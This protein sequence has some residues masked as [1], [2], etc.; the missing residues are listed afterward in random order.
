MNLSFISR[1]IIRVISSPSSST[2]GLFTWIFCDVDMFVERVWEIWWFLW[3]DRRFRQLNDTFAKIWGCD[4]KRGHKGACQKLNDRDI[5]ITMRGSATWRHC[6]VCCYTCNNIFC[7][8]NYKYKTL[9]NIIDGKLR[10]LLET[11]E[12]QFDHNALSLGVPWENL[13][14]L[15]LCWI[16]NVGETYLQRR[17]QGVNR[18]VITHMSGARTPVLVLHSETGAGAVHNVNRLETTLSQSSFPSASI[19]PLICQKHLT[20]I[21]RLLWQGPS[22]PQGPTIE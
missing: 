4:L 8:I 21:T 10:M 19:D 2:K 1:Q 18:C 3:V 9:G 5:C 13:N 20:I 15:I 12:W 22:R 7:K 11:P 6:W 16:D 14:H 17:F